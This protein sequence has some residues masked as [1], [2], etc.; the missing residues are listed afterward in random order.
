MENSS[1]VAII[2]SVA[3]IDLAMCTPADAHA[4]HVIR[5]DAYVMG[6]GARPTFSP[7]YREAGGGAAILVSNKSRRENF[8]ASAR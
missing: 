6:K 4:Q 7:T 1:R 8:N 2:R 5:T 3:V